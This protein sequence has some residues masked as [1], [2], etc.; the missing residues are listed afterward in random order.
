M[1]RTAIIRTTIRRSGETAASGSTTL[2][3]SLA[4]FQFSLI[5]QVVSAATTLSAANADRSNAAIDRDYLT[6][7]VSTLVSLSV[8]V[9][10]NASAGFTTFTVTK[11]GVP[12]LATRLV[13]ALSTGNFLI[14]DIPVAYV[15]GDGVGILVDS[16]THTGAVTAQCL[17]NLN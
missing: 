12:T 9:I 7:K 6:M 17:V 8:N 3:P 16:E 1:Q 13:P 10:A 4:R 5:S 2:K 14:T 11:N 15:V